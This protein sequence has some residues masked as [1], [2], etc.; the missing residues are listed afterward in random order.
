MSLEATSK[1]L[2]AN[3]A[4]AAVAYALSEVIALYPITPATPMGESSDAWAAD[5]RNLRPGDASASD[6]M[7]SVFVR[8]SSRFSGHGRKSVR[9]AAARCYRDAGGG[10]PKTDPSAAIGICSCHRVPAR[11]FVPLRSRPQII[12]R[13]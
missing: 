2:D 1:T 8:V 7:A 13:K 10:A 3:E 11:V 9:S 5:G 4:V 6:V 12:Q